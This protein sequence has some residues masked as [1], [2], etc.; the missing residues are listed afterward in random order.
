MSL[1]AQASPYVNSQN[2]HFSNPGFS[3][4]VG[5]VS[6][7][8]GSVTSE[9]A[10]EQ[11]GMYNMVNVGGRKYRRG[12]NRNKIR[13]KKYR[14]G[15]GYGFSK[16]QVL[17]D[18]SGVTNTGGSV[19]LADF[20]KYTN[21]QVKSD[22]NMGASSGSL[23]GGGSY[24]G[25][26][27]SG[28]PLSTFSGSGYPPMVKG[29]TN[30]CPQVQ[31]NLDGGNSKRRRKTSKKKSKTNKKKSKTNKK[32]SKTNKKKKS[33]TNKKKSVKIRRVRKQRGGYSQY[34]SNIANT[35]S[36]STGAPPGLSSTESALASP[37]PFT[38]TNDCVNSWK[39]LGDMP[40]YNKLY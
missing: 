12:S 35:P 13:R 7:C 36:Y 39:H 1:V 40:P 9:L 2:A 37:V 8:G 28:E 17:A 14:G 5:A 20:S 31:M 32:K 22:T 6:G 38:P 3:S 11:G 34:M 26:E 33:K 21:E 19:H 30:Q 15:D 24:Y 18:T 29:S 10:L 16:D 27:N 23:I 25:F 4:K